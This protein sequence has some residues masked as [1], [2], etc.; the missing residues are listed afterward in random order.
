MSR[1]PTTRSAQGSR[2][3]S[4]DASL[5]RRRFLGGTATALGTVGAALLA[6]PAAAAGRLL[7]AVP[8]AEAA[9]LGRLRRGERFRMAYAPHFGMFRHHAG[10]DPVDQITFMAE[11][12]FTAIEDNGMAGRSIEEQERIAAALEQH[13]MRMGVFVANFGT[14]FGKRSFSSGDPAHLE[15]FLADLTAAVDVARRVNATWMT[16]VLGD[17][18]P[19][20]EMEYQTAHAIEMLKRGAAIFEP[21][22]RVMVLEPLNPWRD[23]PGMFLSRIPQAYAICKAVGSPA[24]KILDDLYH[25]QIAEGNLIPNIDKAWDEIAYFQIGDNPGRNEPTTGEIHYRNVF[26]HIHAK[27][28]TGILGMEHGNSRGG[29][30]GERA[31]IDAYRWCDGF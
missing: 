4:P 10:D 27:G 2:A 23:H 1:R 6:A 20:L 11:E 12:G 14:A 30:E 5:A 28:Y 8:R 26:G 9:E 21:H 3:P 16:V 15:N 29:P 31:V 24:V 7:T 17:L 18:E 25:Q 19:R 22:E 13:D